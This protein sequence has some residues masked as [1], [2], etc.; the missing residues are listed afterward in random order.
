MWDIDYLINFMTQV[1]VDRK[2]MPPPLRSLRSKV[3]SP[4]ALSDFWVSVHASPL[5]EGLYAIWILL[6]ET[7]QNR[8]LRCQLSVNRSHW[9]EEVS[10]QEIG[11]KLCDLPSGSELLTASGISYTG[12]VL[13]RHGHRY[14]IHETWPLPPHNISG[15][16]EIPPANL[17]GR[18]QE[19]QP[20]LSLTTFLIL[21]LDHLDTGKLHASSRDRRE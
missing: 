8:I 18:L 14:W 1:R 19:V 9:Q 11:F 4:S 2:P 3:I 6:E 17:N 12:D 10:L 16:C 20:T 15:A 13:A 5:Q 21:N 7:S